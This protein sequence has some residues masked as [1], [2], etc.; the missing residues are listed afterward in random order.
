MNIVKN[1]PIVVSGP[2]GSGKTELLGYVE[3]KFP[4]FKEAV[5]MTTRERR[6]NENGRM[7]FVTKKEF[8]DLIKTGGLIEYCIY[9][10]N[11]YGVPKSEY[12]KLDKYHLMFNVGYSAAK[13]IKRD[14][15]NAVMIYLLPP[16]EEEL[17][18]RM[19]NREKIRFLEGIKETLENA[20]KYD[21]LL[22]SI[23]NDLETTSN[24]FMDIVYQK[25]DYEQKKLV[26]AKNRDFINN[27]YKNGGHYDL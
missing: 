18:R 10:N 9:N 8:E 25:S 27:F 5:G 14:Y 21:Y 26:L 3:N 20:K 12:K 22:I 23:T 13:E 17:L 19:G 7:E 4:D 1:D 2:S 24:D 16:N 15:N 11:Y 6:I